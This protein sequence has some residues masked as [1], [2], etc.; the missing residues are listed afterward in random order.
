M[1]ELAEYTETDTRVTLSDDERD[2]LI[3][4]AT[5]LVQYPPALLDDNKWLDAAVDRASELPLRIRRALRRF[6]LDPGPDGLLL[7]SNLGVEEHLLPPTPCRPMSAEREATVPSA[8]Q[9]MVALSLG[10][11]IAYRNEKDG[12]LVQNVVPLPGQEREQSNAGSKYMEMHVE[13]AFHRYRPNYVLLQC[14]RNDHD[15]NAE[16]LTSSLRRAFVRLSLPARE[17]LRQER[18]ITDPPPSFGAGEG[19]QHAVF[20]GPNEDPDLLVDFNATRPLDDGA[21]A[22]MTELKTV[23]AAGAT[24]TRL[25]SGDLAIVDNRLVAHGRSDFV[26]R[27]DGRDRWLMRS[28]VHLDGRRSLGARI[29]DSRVIA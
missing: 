12:A 19:V 20:S 9:L 29:E 28:F 25:R 7:L 26:P 4:L 14:L 6:Q 2:A 11:V 23:M 21:V 13:N 5:E 8:I 22:A 17:V 15:D 18:F 27:Y 16:L 10:E 24:G 3:G 1:D